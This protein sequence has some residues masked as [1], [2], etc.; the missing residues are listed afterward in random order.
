MGLFLATTEFRLMN[1]RHRL[2]FRQVMKAVWFESYGPSGVLRYGDWPRPEVRDHQ[3]LIE[4]HAASINPR[5]WLIRSGKYW[6][7]PP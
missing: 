7:A 3:V 4:V 1:Q 2:T 5:D 6:R